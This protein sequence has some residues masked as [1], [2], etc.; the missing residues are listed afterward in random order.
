M[1]TINAA[2]AA[3]GTDG[4]ATAAAN[5]TSLADAH[6]AM[7]RLGAARAHFD[8]LVAYV[9]S[10]VT[11]ACRATN[12]HA[13]ISALAGVGS[14]AS[15][16]CRCRCVC[17]CGASAHT[18]CH[19]RSVSCLF[20]CGSGGNGTQLYIDASAGA[21]TAALRL[22]EVVVRAARKHA[23]WC[24]ATASVVASVVD[25]V[26]PCDARDRASLRA[27]CARS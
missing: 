5:V 19:A 1:T 22:S 6:V 25:Q 11:S 18:S 2:S 3:S 8:S 17:A 21:P 14:A 16:A 20:G 26:A 7:A 27:R 12:T 15:G 24:A 10:G 4:A 23:A 9:R 13:R